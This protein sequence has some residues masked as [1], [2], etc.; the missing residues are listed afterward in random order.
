MAGTPRRAHPGAAARPRARL[1]QPDKG[2]GLCFRLVPRRIRFGGHQGGGAP[3]GRDPP[4]ARLGAHLAGGDHRRAHRLHRRT[5][6]RPLH[7]SH[8]GRRHAR[9]YAHA[10]GGHLLQGRRPVGRYAGAGGPSPQRSRQQRVRLPV[11]RGTGAV[12]PLAGRRDLH[13]GVGPAADDAAPFRHRRSCASSRK[14]RRSP[15][16]S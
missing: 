9:G 4:R 2:D 10:R 6:R 8:A 15:C 16:S 11:R 13:R 3:A 7:R 12:H 5:A 1:A 14:P